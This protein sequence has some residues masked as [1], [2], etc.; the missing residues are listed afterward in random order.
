MGDEASRF[1]AR[2]LAPG[3]TASWI[4]RLAAVAA[5]SALPG[6]AC[7]QDF[8]V[9]PVRFVIGPAPDLLPRMISQKLGE[10][11]G[12]Q[13]VVDQRPGAS[14]LIS[15][16]IVARSPA[17]GYTWIM[18][19]A[20]F[21]IVSTLYPKV[22]Y[23]LARDFT[24]VTLMASLPWIA[25]VHPGVP[26]KSLK[27]LVALAK[28]RPG[29]LNYASAGTGTSTHL[30]TEMFKINS[31]A[32]IVHIPYK[33][34]AAGVTD[35]LGGQVQ[36]MFVIAQAAV[37]HVLSGKLRGLAVTS[38]RRSPALPDLPTV[39]ESGYPDI[40]MVGWNGLH[41]PAK[42]PRAII[43]KIHE[44]IAAVLA[45]PDMKERMVAAGFDLA[46]TSIEEF[47]AYVKRDVA[48]YAKVVNDAHIRIV[49]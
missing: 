44:E 8:P 41:V 34:V 46:A 22:P 21:I 9:R 29:K 12:Q 37:P 13:V 32:D 23:D 49:E 27:E 10:R 6:A 43:K 31:G 47:D 40:D 5:F 24:P 14:G 7:A 45:M 16:E 3:L 35:V 4:V 20:T 28:T 25:V 38:T 15:G 2:L 1:V 36:M 30:V 33:S 19:S 39:A 17:D 42:T 26:V 11:W 18:S 48:R